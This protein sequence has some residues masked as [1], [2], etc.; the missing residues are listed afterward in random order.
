MV[1]QVGTTN[2]QST[3][4]ESS[5]RPVNTFVEPVTVVPKTSLMGLA[6]TLSDINPTLQKFVNFQIDKAKQEGIL[7]GQN[8]LLGADDNKINEIKKELSEKNG[9]RI[10]RNFVGGNVYIEYGIEK[11]LAMNLGNIAEGK[12]NQFFANHF[13]QVQNKDGSITPIP[14]S[15]F[16]V[17]SK[18]FQNAINEFKETQLLDT[19]GIRPELLNR[20]F[21]PQQNAALLKAIT[22]QVEAKADANIQNYTSMLTDSSLLYFRNIDK[23]NENIEADIIDTDFENGESYALSLLQ[24]D[25]KYT[26]N[27]GLSEVV[28]PSGMIEIIK[29]NGYRILNDFE[30]GKISWVEAQSE[31]DEYID[32]M[33]QVRVGPSGTTKEGLT[34][35]KTLGDFLNQDDSILE[36]KREVY[37]KIKDVNKEEQDLA[38]LLNKKDITETL[39][40]L[41]WTSMDQATYVNNVKTL[42]ELVA[43]HKNLKKFIVEEYNL[44]NDNVDLWFDRFIRDY[45]NG[46][47]G[48]KDNARVKL[49][50]FMAVLGPTVS[51]EDRTR[52]REALKLINRENSQGVLSSYPEFETNLQNM[53]EALREDNKSG[54][55]V[56]K[57][58][59]TNAFNDLAKRYRDKIDKWAITDYATQED[60]DKAKDEIINFLKEE[61]YNILTDNYQFADPLLKKLYELTNKQSSIKNNQ[62]LKNLKNLANGGP[63]NKDEPVIVGDNPDGSINK[64]TELFVPKSD[65]EI[66]AGNKTIIHEVKSGENLSTIADQYEGIEYTDIIDFNK[67]S[68]NQANNLSIGQKIPLPQPKI[69]ESK[70]VLTRKLNEVLKDVDTTKP[71]KQDII[72]KMLLA[73]GFSEEDAKIMSAIGMA[74]SAGD[75]DIDTIK[76]GLDPNKKK[77]FSIGLFQINMLPEFE[78]ERF[79][80]FGITSTDELYNPITNVIAAKRLFDKYG[81]EAWGAY[82]N[83]RYKDFLSN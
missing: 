10:M 58:G 62:N 26:Y 25:T 3:A 21:F 46:K 82:K 45:N 66:I 47:F 39:S 69:Q 36:L 20:F 53:K 42:K 9:N 2:F 43:R 64:T 33:L 40:S 71:F 15:Q 57:V 72:N 49:D 34:V 13:V 27:L 30:K 18:E 31:F 51:N 79:P 61:T 4:G 32:F 67:F 75:G 48:N 38:E 44:R 50:S 19:K 41:D 24:E 16:D 6:E 35:Q 80:L 73:V 65:G 11:Q 29:K 83:N 68:N 76:S 12:T 59:Y 81:F 74:E 77:E 54:Y 1:L 17:N 14:L 56:V 63:V 52:Y 55:T 28:S 70:E 37:Q 8:L 5:R 22:K 23:Y 60:K 7:E 78:G